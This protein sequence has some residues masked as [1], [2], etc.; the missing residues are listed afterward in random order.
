MEFRRCGEGSRRLRSSGRPPGYAQGE[1]LLLRAL[2]Q[3]TRTA[4]Q[5]RAH[6]SAGRW[7][8]PH[9]RSASQKARRLL[10]ND[11]DKS[12]LSGQVPP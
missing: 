2:A 3:S 12:T 11:P 7:T 8:P 5:S 1:G 10:L 6:A 9:R 4:G